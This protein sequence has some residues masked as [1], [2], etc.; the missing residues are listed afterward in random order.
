MLV[1]EAGDGVPGGQGSR[2]RVG[3]SVA[4][5]RY[6]PR[7]IQ[8]SILKMISPPGTGPALIKRRN[9]MYV[10]AYSCLP[11]VEL[12]GFTTQDS[13]RVER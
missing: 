3:G 2:F 6:A 7:I 13:F 5:I 9:N 1:A 8:R 11:F 10:H 4:S 12:V